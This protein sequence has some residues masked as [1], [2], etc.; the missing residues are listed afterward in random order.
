MELIT[1]EPR[2]E[3]TCLCRMRKTKAQSDQRLC[4]S[5]PRYYNT[6]SFYIRNFKPLPSFCGC[7]GRLESTLVAHPEDIFSRDE[8][9]MWTAKA[10]A[11]VRIRTVSHHSLRCSL[12]Q[13]R[14]LEEASDKKPEICPPSGI[15][16]MRVWKITNRTSL[17][18]FFS[19]YS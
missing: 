15:L 7:A 11:S 18:P 1:Y 17:R 12:T 2:H 16:S 19:W 4:C 5:L 8:A 9:H 3:K 14:E 13:Y 10:Y 6:S